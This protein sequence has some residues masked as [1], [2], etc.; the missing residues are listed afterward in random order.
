[1]VTVCPGCVP[2]GQVIT[3]QLGSLEP[4]GASFKVTPET[5]ETEANV[6][7]CFRVNGTAGDL[8]SPQ[9]VF[10]RL[11]GFKVSPCLAGPAEEG[12][13]MPGILLGEWAL[14]PPRETL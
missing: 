9:S 5:T 12:P 11:D 3:Y 14:L 2:A 4:F 13:Q 7:K 10:P 1:M 6:R 8:I